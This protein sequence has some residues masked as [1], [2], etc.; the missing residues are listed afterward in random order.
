MVTIQSDGVGNLVDALCGRLPA[1]VPVQLPGAQPLRRPGILTEIGRDRGDFEE[2]T[3]ET[4]RLTEALMNL[5]P[6]EGTDAS[7]SRRETPASAH[8]KDSMALVAPLILEYDDVTARQYERIVEQDAELDAMRAA[9]ETARGEMDALLEAERTRD[10]EIGLLSNRNADYAELSARVLEFDKE[11]GLLREQTGVMANEMRVLNVELKARAAR[12][13][14]LERELSNATIVTTL[15]GGGDAPGTSTRDPLY[16]DRDGRGGEKG[17]F[18]GDASRA[19]RELARLESRFA[20]LKRRA[21]ST[22]TELSDSKEYIFA[23]EGCL[24]SYQAQSLDVYKQVKAAMHAAERATIQRDQSLAREKAAVAEAAD[25]RGRLERVTAAAGEGAARLAEKRNAR[26]T[27]GLKSAKR[28]IESL[29]GDNARLR[30]SL[31]SAKEDADRMRQERRGAATTTK[32]S[33]PLPEASQTFASLTNV[34]TSREM[35]EAR[36]ALRQKA[37]DESVKQ[38]LRHAEESLMK[39]QEVAAEM[40]LSAGRT[41]QILREKLRRSRKDALRAAK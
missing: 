22:T 26:L 19:K 20:D 10:A 28:A 3:R 1:S 4:A 29:R 6:S 31:A 39:Q 35:D 38:R 9:L 7:S 32:E 30:A 8:F 18:D 33:A 36:F 5:L 41:I 16:R 23:M 25:L 21:H 14:E 17:L 13:A 37:T 15:V 12:C 24:R 2:D 34:A 40:E 11:N 27:D